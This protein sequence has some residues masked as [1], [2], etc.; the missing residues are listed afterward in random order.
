MK[1]NIEINPPIVQP[2]YNKVCELDEILR[3]MREELHRMLSA[4]LMETDEE[5]PYKCDIELNVYNTGIYNPRITA[6][7]QDENGLIWLAI[8]NEDEFSTDF[9]D[10]KTDEQIVILEQLF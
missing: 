3:E 1:T 8:D 9:S 7:Y 6:M 10:L 5:H 2:D 4:F